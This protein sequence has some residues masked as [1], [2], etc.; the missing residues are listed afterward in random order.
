M[1]YIP[2]AQTAYVLGSVTKPGGVSLK[3]NM[4]VTKAVAQAGGLHIMLSSNNA[5]ILRLDEN[6]QRQTIPVN[7][8]QITKGNQEDLPLKE[9]DIVYV[10]E[11]SARRFLFDFKM[12]LPGSV[13]MSPAAMY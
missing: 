11:S 1:V 7:L 12:L 4:T 10:Q 5:T 6:G 3:D 2:F 13:S 9:N 8:A